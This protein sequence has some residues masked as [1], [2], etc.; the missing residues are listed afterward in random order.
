MYQTQRGP[1][2]S[3]AEVVLLQLESALNLAHHTPTPRWVVVYICL[4]F[5]VFFCLPYPLTHFSFA[6]LRY[7]IAFP[8]PLLIYNTRNVCRLI[9]TYHIIT[10]FCLVYILLIPLFALPLGGMF[11]QHGPPARLCDNTFPALRQ[12]F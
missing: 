7:L 11:L 2:H 8:L 12:R 10:P 1:N 6:I 5:P 3:S 9:N 4:P